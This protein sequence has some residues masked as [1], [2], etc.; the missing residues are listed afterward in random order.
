[1]VSEISNFGWSLSP[2]MCNYY[3]HR[4]QFFSDSIC[5]HCIISHQKCQTHSQS[6]ITFGLCSLTFASRGLQS[7]IC[8]L[9]LESKTI[10]LHFLQT[11]NFI[12]AQCLPLILLCLFLWSQKILFD[13][14]HLNLSGFLLL[15]SS[16]VPGF[17]NS[18]ISLLL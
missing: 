13:L 16:T 15:C 8:T 1:M 4:V 7:R 2:L 6:S 3:A 17:E 9:L 10:L 11:F 18:I 14:F 12:L 5:F